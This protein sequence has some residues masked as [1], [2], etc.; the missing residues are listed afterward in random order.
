MK[1]PTCADVNDEWRMP[2][3]MA[4]T[5]AAVMRSRRRIQS[6]QQEM[7]HLTIGTTIH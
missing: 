4:R 7:L 2:A 6:T 1:K 5:P 3:V